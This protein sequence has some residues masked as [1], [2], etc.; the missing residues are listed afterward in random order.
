MS[1][2]HSRSLAYHPGDTGRT[3]KVTS[4]ISRPCGVISMTDDLETAFRGRATARSDAAQK[5]DRTPDMRE[6]NDDSA[7]LLRRAI[8]SLER[9]VWLDT[10]ASAPGAAVVVDA[11][12]SALDA[13]ESGEF[14]TTAW[15]AW[16]AEA[17]TSFARMI[18]VP[19]ETV[20]L[21]AS[22]AEAA[23]IVAQSVKRGNVAV[24]ETEFRSNLFPWLALRERG[25]CVIEAPQSDGKSRGEALLETIDAH[26]ELVAVSEVISATGE[27]VDLPKVQ[28]RCRDVGARLFVNLTQ[29][30]GALRFDAR[31]I[32]ADYVA[33][34]GYKWLLAPRGAA[35]L[36]TRSDR[37]EELTP[38]TPGWRSSPNPHGEFFGGPLAFSTDARRLDA[39]F[40]WLPWIGAFAALDLLSTLDAEEIERQSLGLAAEFRARAESAGHAC[41][42]L[43][44]PSQIVALEVRNPQRVRAE[45]E[46]RRVVAAMRGSLLRFGFHGFNNQADVDAALDALRAAA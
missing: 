27:R 26:T 39:S 19:P 20:A 23:A 7:Q 16:A 2:T 44:E 18:H 41:V 38:L 30:L 33:V 32:D 34:H 5:R 31:T 46:R 4:H 13:W 37:L 22:L 6:G 36:H 3:G 25:I 14:D 42:H 45:L 40:A 8:P 43:G 24:A 29:S 35:W 10:P 1:I 15:E 21:T 11:L 28:Q 17:R 12:R 9:V